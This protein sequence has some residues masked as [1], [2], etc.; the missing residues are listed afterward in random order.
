MGNSF[1]PYHDYGRGGRGWRDLWQDVLA[2]LMMERGDVSEMLLGYFGGVRADGSN[3][4]IIGS[5]PGEFR[6]DRNNIP[7]VW[8]DHGAWPLLT[9]RLYIDQSGDLEFLYC[10]SRVISKTT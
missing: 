8:M 4:T 6:A 3:A 2:L 7:R 10:G 9:T 5:Q 1:L